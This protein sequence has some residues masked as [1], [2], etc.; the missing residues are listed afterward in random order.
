MRKKFTGLQLFLELRYFIF[1][2]IASAS[3]KLLEKQALLGGG[4]G[5]VTP[6]CTEWLHSE[7][8]LRSF[9]KAFS[10]SATIINTF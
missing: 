4:G 5:G 1:Q 10:N 2:N 9:K 7:A 8:T 6:G 3:P